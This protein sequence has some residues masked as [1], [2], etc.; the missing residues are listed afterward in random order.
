MALHVVKICKATG[1]AKHAL[2][3]QLALYSNILCLLQQNTLYSLLCQVATKHCK[4]KDIISQMQVFWHYAS[5]A[6][7]VK[8]DL[9]FSGNNR[10]GE[11]NAKM[12]PSG[13][14]NINVFLRLV[15][16]FLYFS[17][18]E[19][20]KCEVELTLML[21]MFFQKK[22]GCLKPFILTSGTPNNGKDGFL[23]S[24]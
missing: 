19:L 14:N 20:K 23:K 9:N 7:V 8:I 6:D 15:N 11:Y 22:D 16:A 4:Q 5:L 12:S 2:I 3:Y 21:S 18:V 13:A 17:W 1:H 10:P 24:Q